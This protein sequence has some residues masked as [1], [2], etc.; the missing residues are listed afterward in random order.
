MSANTW[1]VIFDYRLKRRTR[2]D[3][4]GEKGFIELGPWLDVEAN[5]KLIYNKRLFYVVK[6][7]ADD[8]IKFGIAGLDGKSSGWGRLHQYINYHGEATELNHCSGIKLLYLAGT[9]YNPN[10]VATNSAVFRK[11]LFIKQHFRDTALKGRGFER[12]LQAKLDE[13]F[14]LID[15]KSNRA[16]EDI[17]LERRRTERLKQAEIVASDS[18]IKVLSH[19]TEPKTQKKT[20][21]LVQW[22]RPYKLTKLKKVKGEVLLDEYIEDDTTYEPYAK[23]IT[24]LDG[25]K[26]VEVYK[27]LHPTAK[28]R[29]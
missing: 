27:A 29:D 23:L 26:A 16:W 9:I 14:K 13:L 22:S 2:S 5:K 21:Y 17:E 18:V 4:K 1:K 10:V 28:Y 25:A 7:N 12:I 24:Y 11:E 3:V 8:I 6:A 15:D 20:Q 19:D